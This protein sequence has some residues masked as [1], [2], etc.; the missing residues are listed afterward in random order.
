MRSRSRVVATVAAVAAFAL[1]G[2][3]LAPGAAALDGPGAEPAA[4]EGSAFVVALEPDG[5]ATVS[6]VLTYDL[7]DADD[8]A[9]FE[10]L[11]ERPENVTARFDD[12][13]ARIADRTATQVDREMSVS[14]VRTEIE[15]GDGTGVVRLSATWTNLAVVD[16]DRLVVSEPF[17]SEFRPDR[18]FVLVAPD[19]YALADTT[20]EADATTASDGSD[21]STAEWAAGTDLSGFSAAFAPSDAAGVTDG[22]LPTPLVPTLALLVAGLLGYAGWRRA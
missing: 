15:S 12:R 21:A 6:L 10:D 3:L 16:G 19:G 11:R 7:A 2:V 14:D 4:E 1:V 17:A 18:P 22:S 9:A 13:I 20:V 8:E 5:D